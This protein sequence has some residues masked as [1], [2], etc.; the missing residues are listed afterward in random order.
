MSKM[1][2]IM[3][4]AIAASVALALFIMGRRRLH[5]DEGARGT[6]RDRFLVT[7]AFFLALLGG[8]MDR[9]GSKPL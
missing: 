9:A 6:L 8:V 5:V 7:V 1:L 4:A 3:L 2:A